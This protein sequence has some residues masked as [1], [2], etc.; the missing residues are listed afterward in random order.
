VVDVL[1]NLKELRFT[2]LWVLA[3]LA[4]AC[5]AVVYYQPIRSD[6]PA[7]IIPWLYLGAI[8]FNVLTV[9]KLVDTLVILVRAKSS[10]PCSISFAPIQIRSF[11]HLAEQSDGRVFTQISIGLLATNLTN[12]PVGLSNPKILKSPIGLGR[13]TLHLDVMIESPNNKVF[14]STE[15]SKY[16]LLPNL[17]QVVVLHGFF[18]RTP[19]FFKKGILRLSIEMT[20][21]QGQKQLL[22]VQ[23][24]HAS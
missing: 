22:A 3:G 10:E 13:E 23:L 9:T 20:D 21:T 8:F 1:N 11:W 24:K 17:P 7:E 5:D 15:I 6:L 12:S 19:W 4:I 16:A 18:E 14:G 2:P